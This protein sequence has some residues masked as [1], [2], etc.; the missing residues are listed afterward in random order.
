VTRNSSNLVLSVSATYSADG[1]NTAAVTGGAPTTPGYYWL[2]I[3]STTAATTWFAPSAAGAAGTALPTEWA[4]A[5]GS[6]GTFRTASAPL[7]GLQVNAVPLPAAVWLLG[8]GIAG[9]GAFA[10][11]RRR[12]G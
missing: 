1:W 5:A 2:A 12:S 11:R 3:E 8:S 9:L 6:G 7:V 10:R 4:S